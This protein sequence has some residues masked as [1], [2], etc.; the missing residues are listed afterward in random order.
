MLQS[1]VRAGERDQEILFIQKVVATNSFNEDA[2]ESW[3]PVT[4][5]PI[6]FARA[7]EKVR[8]RGN[9]EVIADRITTSKVT[10]FTVEWRS[11]ITTENHRV[12]WDGRVYNIVSVIEGAARRVALDIQAELIDSEVYALGYSLGFTLGFTA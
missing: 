7:I 6:V 10:I 12:V 3:V 5:N 11:D 1:R 4:T 8:P 2:E 9:E